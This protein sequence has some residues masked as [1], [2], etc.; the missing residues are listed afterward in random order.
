MKC[1]DDKYANSQSSVWAMLSKVV[2]YIKVYNLIIKILHIHKSS[3]FC[4]MRYMQNSG[5]GN[6]DKKKA[7]KQART[8][9]KIKQKM[10][11]L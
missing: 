9:C 8:I 11:L 2:S 10:L 7:V 6:N 1:T 3:Q 5:L 4:Q